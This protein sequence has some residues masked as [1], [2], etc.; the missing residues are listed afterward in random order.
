APVALS[1]IDLTAAA[2]ED[3]A[4][5]LLWREGARPFDLARDWMIRPCLMR[6]G[7]RDHLLLVT[8]HHIA[9]DTWSQII[10][11][12]E[13]AE[14]YTAYT[15]GREPR[16]PALEVQYADFASWQR[17][18]LRDQSLEPRIAYWTER[19]GAQPPAPELP[20]DRPR[21]PVETFAG[22]RL[23][24]RLDPPLVTRLEAL[25]RERGV[26]LFMTMLAIFQALLHRHTGQ[27]DLTIGTPVGGRPRPE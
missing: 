20:T 17:E 24:V 21:P 16:L 3:E 7:P 10:L 14:L 26:T 5:R 2:D 12:R 8:V 27:D 25:S 4:M 9:F 19:L 22:S 15:S 13:L 11:H 18:R 23:R 1:V 6:L